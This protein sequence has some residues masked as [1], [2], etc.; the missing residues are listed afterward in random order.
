MAKI[1]WKNVKGNQHTSSFP[2]EDSVYSSTVSA[3]TKEGSLDKA[4]LEVGEP[5]FWGSTIPV[6]DDIVCIEYGGDTIP[7]YECIFTTL[8]VHMPFTAFEVDVFNHLMM[9]HSQ[10]H[11]SN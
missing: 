3:F 8:G 1:S 9:A 10:L 4:F 7:L 5:F 11:S 6:E 2:W